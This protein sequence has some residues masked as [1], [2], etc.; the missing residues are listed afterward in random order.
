MFCYL[1]RKNKIKFKKFFT[2]GPALKNPPV[3][4]PSN[5][6]EIPNKTRHK[7]GWSVGKK[8]SIERKRPE[9]KNAIEL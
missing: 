4:N 2:K 1:K 5:P 8:A 7:V 3:V 9:P 6:A